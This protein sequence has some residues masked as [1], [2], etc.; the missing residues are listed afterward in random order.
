MESWTAAEHSLCGESPEHFADGRW[1]YF[2]DAWWNSSQDVR[3][4]GYGID[5][6]WKAPIIPI[7]EFNGDGI[8][9]S[10]DMC[11]MIDHWGTNNKLC[12][13]G[14]MP[15]G[16]G[17][18]DIEDLRILAEYL[19]EGISDPTLVAHWAL[20]EAEG[21]TAY[22]TAADCDGTLPRPATAPV[23]SV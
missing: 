23:T 15:W 10:A 3:P 11:I 6:L 9:D 16:D 1:L 19:F 17:I 13:I 5:D 2:S 21:A 18:V 14:P 22:D 7:V 8:V 12:D 20:D 4:G